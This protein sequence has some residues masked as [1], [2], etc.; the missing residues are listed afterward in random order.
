MGKKEVVEAAFAKTTDI[1]SAGVVFIEGVEGLFD[2]QHVAFVYALP[3]GIVM[4]A[5]G[6]L[7][8]GRGSKS[9]FDSI[10]PICY[11]NLIFRMRFMSGGSCDARRGIEPAINKAAQRNN[12]RIGKQI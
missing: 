11:L 6:Y 8:Y 10:I 12:I 4:D 3:S 1:D 2:C 7:M 9:G 5:A